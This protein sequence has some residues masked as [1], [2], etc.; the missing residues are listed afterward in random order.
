MDFTRREG[1]DSM[2]KHVIS[3]KASQMTFG[4][5][6]TMAKIW[7]SHPLILDRHISWEIRPSARTG[8]PG[9]GFIRFS[10]ARRCPS[11]Q[12]DMTAFKLVGLN[13]LITLQIL[14][15]AFFFSVLSAIGR[16]YRDSKCARSTPQGSRTHSGSSVETVAGHCSVTGL[17]SVLGD[18]GPFAPV[19]R[20]SRRRLRSLI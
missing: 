2:R 8:P 7:R 18:P 13:T 20:W 3:R 14:P 1:C 12:T 6:C 4:R 5:S 17:L 15:S 10:A 9:N 16:L 19:M 11:P